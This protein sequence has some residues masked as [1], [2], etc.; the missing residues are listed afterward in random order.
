MSDAG[1][2]VSVTR[3]T[4]A[5]SGWDRFWFH[6]ASTTRVA[7]IRGL[8]C[9]I[10]A[11][12]FMSCWSD[13]AFWYTDEGPL[14][15]SRVSS[16][17]QVGGLEDAARWIVSPLFLT[18]S[19]WVYR[20][21]LLLGIIVAGMVA[22]GRGGRL[23]CWSLWLLLVGWANRAMILSSLAESLLS[24]GLFASAIAPPGCCWR[25]SWKT[26]SQDDQLHWTAGFS[27][28]L[29]AVQITVIGLATWIT[30]LGGR[31]WFNG[32]GAYALAAPAGDRTID[33]TAIEAFSTNST[34]QELLTHGMVLAL[35]L[36]FLLAWLPRP[37][38]IGL[39]ILISWC[40]VVS[41]LGSHWIY[42]LTFAT[43]VLAIRSYRSPIL[44]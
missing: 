12:Y 22:S 11:V 8:L 26:D 33:W 1:S 43:M 29:T 31:V 38:R 39:A 16:F 34:V 35:P 4:R 36:G 3:T 20:F 25:S 28:R 6:P 32:I 2:A 41:L 44:G 7:T 9:G 37:R 23:A 19:V 5:A 18:D 21:Y 27:E 30:M 24:L 14:S 42:A 13:A 40:V 10:T 15:A 17:L